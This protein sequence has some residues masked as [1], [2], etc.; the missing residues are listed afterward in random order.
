MRDFLA[1]TLAESPT[2]EWMVY[3]LGNVPGLPP[4]AQSFHIMGIATV[5]GSIVM[6]DLKFLGLALPNQNV[7]EMIRRLL[8]WTW[9]ALAANFVT[10]LL[11]IL[12]RPNRYFY[13]PVATFKF[14]ALLLAAALAFGVYWMNRKEHGYWEASDDRL[15]A[16]RSISAA[17]LLLW[18]GVMLGGR[19]IAYSEYITD[20]FTL[21]F[22]WA[23][24]EAYPTFLL[25]VQDHPISQ[26]IGF[27]WWFPLLESIHVI[28]IA[29]V[30]GSIVT[31]DLRLLGLTAMRYPVSEVTRKLVPWTWAAFVVA[32]V[33]GL[34]MFVTRAPAYA[35]N[36]AFQIKFLLLPL[37]FANMA[38]FQFRT[39][40]G[41]AG[42]DTAHET[43]D[44]ARFAGGASLLL[45][46]GV[47]IAGRWTGHLI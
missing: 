1:Q 47:V 29:L 24:L 36:T 6:V 46:A 18:I 31:V 11:F 14:S 26:H 9:Y 32:A 39:F 43:P 25:W 28:A 23:A 13:N 19:W 5:V 21:P 8:P 38:Y 7:S 33:T 41:V 16:A 15:F 30:V 35:D 3:L 22:D 44:A 4:I 10:G 20:P 34:G 37:A 42:W 40:R 2:R 12:A 45:W 17:S 27:T